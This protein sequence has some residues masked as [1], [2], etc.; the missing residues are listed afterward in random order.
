VVEVRLLAS[1]RVVEPE[2]VGTGSRREQ[3]LEGRVLLVEDE[4]AVL[5]FERDVLAG[6]GAQVV[7]LMNLEEVKTRLRTETFDAVIINGRMPGGW[8]AQDAHRWIGAA[9]PGLEKRLLFTF[10]SIADAEI[11]NYLQANGIAS[12]VKPFEVADLISQARRLLQ[13]T[14]AAIAK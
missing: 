2:A 11:R 13:K 6:A 12:L 9:C 14:Q 8:S 10:S 5:E 3:A 4:E 7:A 1:G